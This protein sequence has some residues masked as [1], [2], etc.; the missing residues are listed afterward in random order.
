MQNFIV[1]GIIPGTNIQVN[2]GMWL[3][4]IASAILIYVSLRRVARHVSSV[5]QL[6]PTIS[7]ENS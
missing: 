1:L 6:P 7:N 3:C 4:V 5:P 2:F